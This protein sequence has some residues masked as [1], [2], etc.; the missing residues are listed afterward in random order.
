MADEEKEEYKVTGSFA[1]N[2]IV[3]FK[4]YVKEGKLDV[5]SV[6]KD[7]ALNDKQIPMLNAELEAAGYF[8]TPDK[9]DTQPLEPVAEA[10]PKKP[11]AEG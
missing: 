5:D 8:K 10:K 9:A 6:K 11:K 3:A 1:N 4:P 7:Y 2:G